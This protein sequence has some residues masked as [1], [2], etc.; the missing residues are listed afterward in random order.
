MQQQGNKNVQTG[1][2]LK[3]HG[4]TLSK[5][6]PSDLDEFKY[7]FPTNGLSS[8]SY[9]WWGDGSTN[10]SIS[11]EENQDKQKSPMKMVDSSDVHSSMNDEDKC[12]KLTDKNDIDSSGTG[13]LTALREKAVK[14]GAE[15]LKLGIHRRYDINKLDQAKKEVLLQIFKSSLPSEWKN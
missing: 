15:A 3:F 6:T 9:R 10:G 11:T 5:G 4:S 2:P 7:G 13:F 1:S 14:E 8:V 12:E